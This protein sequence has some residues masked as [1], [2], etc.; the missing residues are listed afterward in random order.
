MPIKSIL[1]I[2]LTK[3]TSFVTSYNKFS[4][5]Q[6]KT[7]SGAQLAEKAAVGSKKATEEAAAAL[8]GA[9]EALRKMSTY[10]TDAANASRRQSQYWS[11]IAASSKTFATNLHSAFGTALKITGIGS[12]IGGI[13]LGAGVFG[14]ERLAFSAAAGRRSATGLGIGYGQQQAFGTTYNRLMD[15]GSFLGGI[16]RARGDNSSGAA[17]ALYSLGLNPA[18]SGNTYTMGQSALDRIRQLTLQTPESQ[19][20][21]LLQTHNLGELGHDTE[22]LRRIRGMS[23]GEYDQYRKDATQRSKDNDVSDPQLKK[24]QDFTVTLDA[25]GEKL[26]S[27]FIDKLAD[28]AEPL[29]KVIKGFTDAATTI[30]GADG[31]SKGLETL[32]T[33]LT[34]FANYVMSDK[35]QQNAKTLADSIEMLGVKTI[36]ALK[37][38]N[39]IPD[40]NAGKPDSKTGP[41]GLG[42]TPNETRS[43]KDALWRWFDKT[44]GVII[45]STPMEAPLPPSSYDQ[46]GG[47]GAYHAR[48]R[49]APRPERYGADGTLTPD[50]QL[51]LIAKLEGSP[52]IN[53]RSQ[54]S[55]AGAIGK[56]QIMPGTGA[57]MGYS[58]QDLFDP[59]KNEQAARRYIKMLSDR[60]NGNTNDILVGYNAGPGTA[61]KWIANGRDPR[62]LPLET[63]KYLQHAGSLTVTINNNTGSNVN[64]TAAAAG[65]GAPLAFPN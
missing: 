43:N 19:L 15:T 17:T 60:Y 41:F 16:S 59:A 52:D 50:E 44:I 65:L 56:Y 23:S 39:L 45:G 46:A 30:L 64:V 11:G 12:L 1:D 33:G 36:N 53:G 26:K 34:K 21:L 9:A 48:S 57:D 24:W 49:R 42:N 25:A 54:I 5:Q 63:Q 22:S 31:I 58:R 4:Q 8:A 55:P 2:D 20:G 35:F 27:L 32:A 62:T 14:L 29:G 40:A 6:G 47:H 38:L 7:A 51:S 3:W 10:Q 37:F 18:G 61:D 13:G 28:L